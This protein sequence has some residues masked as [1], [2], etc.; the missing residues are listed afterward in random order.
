M[1]PLSNGGCLLP[2]NIVGDRQSYLEVDDG[3]EPESEAVAD[4][5]AAGGLLAVVVTAL[6]VVA[7]PRPWPAGVVLLVLNLGTLLTRG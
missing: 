7:G 4:L 6:A 5:V 3:N 1:K 2:S